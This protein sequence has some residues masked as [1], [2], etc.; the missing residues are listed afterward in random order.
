MVKTSSRN[1]NINQSSKKS[2]SNI[3]SRLGVRSN[4]NIVGK[5][6]NKS[7]ILKKVEKTGPG[8]KKEI[9]L[10]TKHFDARNKIKN[11]TKHNETKTKRIGIQ[12][13]VN[14]IV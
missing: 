12:N 10:F 9:K 5:P 13:K 14:F 3:K 1:S 7:G 8:Q 6:T 4:P 2:K 11:T